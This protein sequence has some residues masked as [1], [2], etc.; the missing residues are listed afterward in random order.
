MKSRVVLAAAALVLS[1]LVAAPALATT[2]PTVDVFGDSMQT[3]SFH[4]ISN[5]LQRMSAPPKLINHVFPGLAIC[6]FLYQM[7]MDATT[8]HPDVVLILFIGNDFTPCMATSAASGTSAVAAQY[9]RDITTAVNTFLTNGTRAIYVF[10]GPTAPT[11]YE[12]LIGAVRAAEESAV[13]AFN[14]PNVKWVD[15]GTSVESPGTE[16]FSLTRACVPYEINHRLCRGPILNGVPQN[17]VRIKDGHFCK[18]PWPKGYFCAG[19]WRFGNAEVTALMNGLHWTPRP[20]TGL[21]GV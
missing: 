2:A 11:Q 8:I 4:Y 1:C 15:A 21:R 3:Q 7:H 9:A 17:L 6:D 16:A 20:A 12:G 19:A 18:W 10:G 14:S 5:D 13:T